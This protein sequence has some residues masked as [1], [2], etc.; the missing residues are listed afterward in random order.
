MIFCVTFLTMNCKIDYLSK[1]LL[2]RPFW[3]PIKNEDEKGVPA[4]ELVVLT[5]EF[6]N[7]GG[8]VDDLLKKINSLTRGN[9]KELSEKDLLFDSCYYSEEF[10]FYFSILTKVNPE[11][12]SYQKIMDDSSI[13]TTTGNGISPSIVKGIT[14]KFIALGINFTDLYQWIYHLTDQ[15]FSHEK[16]NRTLIHE[17]KWFSF[18]FF[19]LIIDLVRVLTNISDLDKIMENAFNDVSQLIMFDKSSVSISSLFKISINKSVSIFSFQKKIRKLNGKKFQFHLNEYNY[20]K[21]QLEMVVSLLAE[22]FIVIMVAYHDLKSRPNVSIEHDTAKDISLTIKI[23]RENRFLF[24]PFLLINIPCISIA[25]IL[26]KDLLINYS[27]IMIAFTIVT[28][29]CLYLIRRNAIL[30]RRVEELEDAVCENVNDNFLQLNHLNRLSM[31]LLEEKSTL[32]NKVED[33]TKELKEANEKLLHIDSEK[34]AFYTNIAHEIRTPLT[35]IISPLEEII[36][37]RGN[38][39]YEKNMHYTER[40]LSNSVKL[41]NLVNNLLDYE[42]LDFGVGSFKPEVCNIYNLLVDYVDNF[43][44]ICAKNGVVI[45]FKKE[46]NSKIDGLIDS[47]LFEKVIM[48]LLSNAVKFSPKN[49]A[50]YI[51]L[52]CNH[53][54]GT[55]EI[56]VE[57]EGP[58]IP[59]EYRRNVFQRFYQIDRNPNIQK[60]GSGIGLALVSE[61]VKLHKGKVDIF[62]SPMGGALIRLIFPGLSENA[63]INSNFLSP[64]SIIHSKPLDNN[65]SKERVRILL[66]EDND[67]MAEHLMDLFEYNVVRVSDG[68]MALNFLNEEELPHIIISDIVMPRMDGL[69][70]FEQLS[71]DSQFKRIPFIFLSAKTEEEFQLS[72]LKS[73]AT[74]YICKPFSSN[75]L[76]AK[77][78]NAL[79]QNKI[80]NLKLN[81]S[82]NKNPFTDFC[83]LYDITDREKDVINL[84]MKGLQNKE[85][86]ASLNISS[87]TV[88]NHIKNIFDKTGVG[89]RV[90]L[91]N[92]ANNQTVGA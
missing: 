88:A 56:E 47:I 48:N 11:I 12:R 89:N 71:K 70:L 77:V 7:R 9:E 87:R 37:S 51:G 29:I 85:I 16:F 65:D 68:E 4:T 3:Y 42:K 91:I 6:I 39:D 46:L 23:Y 30:S 25:Y 15:E 60:N 49:G 83:N 40:A 74:D 73:G 58:G 84:V 22:I 24:I 35:L 38:M 63:S 28:N 13:Y 32:H 34:T 21:I 57:D 72:A 14:K 17:D 76:K 79:R 86:G 62:D 81:A 90:E 55:F 75:L 69:S 45:K 33:R 64:N 1:E 5:N 36:N 92:L 26:Y 53:E 2:I 10:L 19:E 80:S 82:Y 20:S 61:I 27:F 52:S 54:N 18:E 43:A 59:A 66:V 50:I 78:E 44:S 41:R 8:D 67:D 31:S